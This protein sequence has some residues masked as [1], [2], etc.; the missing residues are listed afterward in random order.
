MSK[1]LVLY[2]GGDGSKLS[3]KDTERL[4]K[5]WGAYMEKLQKSGAY[6]DGAAVQGSAATQIVGKAKDIKAKRAGNAASYVGGYCVLEGKSMAGIQRL[7]KTCP[8]LTMMDGTIEIL[9]VMEMP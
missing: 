4:M 6:L 9:P 8:H 2:R 1:F 7:S 5:K 3:P